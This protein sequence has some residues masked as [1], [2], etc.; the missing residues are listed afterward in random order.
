[1]HWTERQWGI[2]LRVSASELI[3]T[4]Y[5][6]LTALGRAG[7]TDKAG[8]GPGADIDGHSSPHDT[9]PGAGG[10]RHKIMS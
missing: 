1:M 3:I 5:Y 9:H 2:T 10:A 8:S 6:H 4:D 7:D